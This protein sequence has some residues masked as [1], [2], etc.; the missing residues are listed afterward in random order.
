[1]HIKDHIAKNWRNL[2]KRFDQ[3]EI[4]EEEFISFR[5]LARGVRRQ[6]RR[7]GKRFAKVLGREF[8]QQ[9]YNH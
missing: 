8:F 2:R 5:N 6:A 1:M 4:S 7:S 3:G 9:P